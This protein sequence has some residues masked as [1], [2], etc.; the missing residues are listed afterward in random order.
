MC[1]CCTLLTLIFIFHIA[2]RCFA[3]RYETHLSEATQRSH[4]YQHQ[5]SVNS[6]TSIQTVIFN[7]N[8]M[9]SSGDDAMVLNGSESLSSILTRSSNGSQRQKTLSVSS[10]EEPLHI[11]DVADLLHPQY[12]VI[13]G[14]RSMDTGSPLIT[15]PDHN[16]F[17][18]LSDRDYQRLIQYLIG[19]TSLQ[20]ADLGFQLIIDRRKNSWASVKAV[21]V[22]VSVRFLLKLFSILNS[23]RL[24]LSGIFPGAHSMRVRPATRRVLPESHLRGQLEVLQGRVPLQ[25]DNLC[26]NRGAARVHSSVAADGRSQRV[27]VLLAPRMDTTKNCEFRM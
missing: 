27:F 21:L 6:S 2:W 26:S 20:D 23:F 25:S 13:T 18:L 3:E 12:A 22:K 10:A 15:F 16:N 24:S 17:H 9:S 8:S 1:C 4:I 11:A 7:A 5:V 14:G 19:V